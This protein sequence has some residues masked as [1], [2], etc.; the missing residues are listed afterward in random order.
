MLRW[1]AF[2]G[3]PVGVGI[4][5]WLNFGVDRDR[6]ADVAEAS[7]TVPSRKA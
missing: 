6:P 7:L 5:G 2:G 3:V 4:A 1:L